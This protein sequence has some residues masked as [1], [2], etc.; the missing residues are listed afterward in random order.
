MTAS[1][2]VEDGN[3]MM[4]IHH[5]DTMLSRENLGIW[6]PDNEEHIMH[7]FARAF[8]AGRENRT[9]KSNQL[10]PV[11]NRIGAGSVIVSSSGAN[12]LM[13]RATD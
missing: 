4:T 1:F 6:L 7:L 5:P 13:D 12:F 11:C 2:K 10:C 8:A 3:L 9:L